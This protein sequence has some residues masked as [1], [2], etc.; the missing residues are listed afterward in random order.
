MPYIGYISAQNL[1][2]CGCAL[3]EDPR[4]LEVAKGFSFPAKGSLRT[5]PETSLVPQQIQ[6]KEKDIYEGS[7]PVTFSLKFLAH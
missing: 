3:Q 1:E 6:Y 5:P 7:I 4:V 2:I